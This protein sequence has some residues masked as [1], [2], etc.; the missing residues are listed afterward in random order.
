MLGIVHYQREAAWGIALVAVM[1]VAGLWNVAQA[2]RVYSP[3]QAA[4]GQA[5]YQAECAMCHQNDLSG[6][7]AAPALAGTNFLNHW[8]NM[9]VDELV[10][11]TRASMPPNNP[12]G[13]SGQT[14]LN[15]TAFV[16][17]ANGAVFGNQPLIAS[18]PVEIGTLATGLTPAG[19]FDNAGPGAI[20][21]PQGVTVVGRVEN[22]VPVT[23]EMKINPDPADWL[24]IR[25]NYQ[26]W[27]YS[28]LTQITRDN[29]SDLRLQW[30]WS[31][32]DGVN[33]VAP[34]VHNGIIYFNSPGNI[35]RAMDA[36][37]G[38]LIWESRVG[39]PSGTMRGIGIT[40]DKIIY[41]RPDSV[42]M[43]LDARNGEIVWDT[44][45]GEGFR[46]TSGPMAIGDTIVA[47]LGGCGT[48]REEKC[49]ISAYDAADGRQIWKFNTV[50][51]DG[52]PGGDTWGGLD[53][54]LRAGAETWITGSYD[55]ELNRTYWGVAQPKPWV[56]AT[57][58]NTVNDDALYSSTTLALN[59]DT[60][61]LDWYYQHAPGEALDL[62]EV[63][64]RVLV[65]AGGRKLVFSIGKHGILW[66]VDRETG[67]YLDH[68]ETVFQN[69]FDSFDPDTGRPQYRVDIVEHE[70]GQWLQGCPSTEGGHNW[71]AMSYHPGT[72]RLIIPLS[73]SC[74]EI[75][76]RQ[77]ALEA[78]SGGN[79]ADR[80]WYEMPGTDGNVGK[81]AA[82]DVNTM[83][84]VWSHQQRAPFLTAVVST[85]SNI[86]FAGDLDRKFRA[87]DVETGEILWETRLGTSVQGFPLIFAV[88]GKEYVA[89]TTGLGGGSPRVVPGLITREIQ[90][91]SNGN[92]IWVFALPDGN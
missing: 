58:G 92:A 4:A 5:A 67:E 2:Q 39:G 91:P 27:N 24:M 26:A 76:G 17:Q 31:M 40:D 89:V 47:G 6:G 32:E 70:T 80:K 90:H 83:E 77:I 51:Q 8:G 7:G 21:A 15:I 64:E 88:D 13:L 69:V 75:R 1:A 20:E 50:A 63:F 73:Q 74:L 28:P 56:P 12:G 18:V 38:E 59:P 16:L 22:F 82:Y 62:D 54:L 43:A 45:M 60:G 34:I 87:F 11:A 36:R 41:V 86:L 30:V 72:E 44:L 46:S 71:Q 55:P 48:Y 35:I 19:L 42:V 66:K 29:V 14:Y 49:Y 33:Q 3:A 79:A 57:R 53:N 52:E 84:E 25:G 9:S 23:A 10:D 68:T 81:L 37:D 61:E 85:G 65:D 78:G